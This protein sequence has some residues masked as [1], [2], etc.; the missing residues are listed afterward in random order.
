M[1]IGRISSTLRPSTRIPRSTIILRTTALSASSKAARTALFLVS[2]T[3][4]AAHTSSYTRLTASARACFSCVASAEA[5][6]GVARPITR[7]ASV[8][9]ERPARLAGLR[10]QLLLHAGQPLA[11]LVA[12]GDRLQH[13]VLGDF[14]GARLDH[15]HAVLGAG[16]DQ[17][18][19][20]GL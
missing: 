14:L 16:H 1:E 6:F 20:R 19:L 7:A 8:R 15:Q 4:S 3:P 11:L 10:R 17:L 18:E 2:S 13:L 9:I 12:E 5:S